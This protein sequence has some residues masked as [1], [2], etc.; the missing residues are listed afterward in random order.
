MLRPCVANDYSLRFV[1]LRQVPM[2]IMW[3]FASALYINRYVPIVFRKHSNDK[4]LAFAQYIHIIDLRRLLQ[5]LSF[6][7]LKCKKKLHLYYW[8][9]LDQN[10]KLLVILPCMYSKMKNIGSLLL[11]QPPQ[12]KRGNFNS[13]PQSAMSFSC[14]VR[15]IKY[16][17][18]IGCYF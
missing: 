14:A 4:M 8:K 10:K 5:F 1:F 11:I 12:G 9:K 7:S 16:C 17:S 6:S 15:V 18:L 3:Q 2:C 13:T